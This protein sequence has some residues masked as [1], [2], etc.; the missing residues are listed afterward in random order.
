METV[1]DL[2]QEIVPSII[3]KKGKGFS[4]LSESSKESIWLRHL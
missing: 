1:V 3:A 4:Y 2:I